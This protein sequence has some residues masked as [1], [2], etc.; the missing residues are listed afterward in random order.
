MNPVISKNKFF[1]KT[2]NGFRLLTIVTKNS[3][4]DAVRILALPLHS[5][6]KVF[7]P[8]PL[9]PLTNFPFPQFLTYLMLALL[10]PEYLLLTDNK[11]SL[12]FD[13]WIKKFWSK[14]CNAQVGIYLTFSAKVKIE[15][16]PVC[17][18]W[19]FDTFGNYHNL[20]TL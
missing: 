9:S 20:H 11:Q 2:V 15:R 12:Y 17:H 7:T 13:D 4:L 5:G 6:Q 18:V 16:D 10:K 8:P 3:V 1:L 19:L 14:G